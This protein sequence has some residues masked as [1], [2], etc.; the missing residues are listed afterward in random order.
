MT[1]RPVERSAIPGAHVRA[2]R[3]ATAPKYRQ[4]TQRDVGHVELA[5]ARGVNARDILAI[6]GI[7]YEQL[8]TVRKRMA[9]DA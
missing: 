3:P 7:S 8:Q 5:L 9:A 2:E 4:L 1:V 6:W